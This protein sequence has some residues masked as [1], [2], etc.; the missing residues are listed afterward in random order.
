MSFLFRSEIH[1]YHKFVFPRTNKYCTLG[2]Q[3]RHLPARRHHH[4]L[5]PAAPRHELVSRTKTRRDLFYSASPSSLLPF[6]VYLF[7]FFLALS[8][9]KIIYFA[10][11]RSSPFLPLS[12]S[13]ALLIPQR[14]D[15]RRHPHV[16][17]SPAPP[18][19][20]PAPVAGDRR[21]STAR[22]PTAAALQA[23]AAT[24]VPEVRLSLFSVDKGW[25]APFARGIL[26]EFPCPCSRILGF[27]RPGFGG[28]IGCGGGRGC[29]GV[30]GHWMFS[31]RTCS[32]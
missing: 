30:S 19:P 4:L 16:V 23:F 32:C 26:I 18:P 24:R 15:D 1:R 9:L 6:P 14:G 12:A 20:T 5:L 28:V 3:Q 22:A 21:R 17:P 31:I 7:F 27:W 8:L 11:S 25:A 13:A 2:F 10:S 29:G